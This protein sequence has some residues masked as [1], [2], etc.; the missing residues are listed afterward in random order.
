M[1]ARRAGGGC[2]LDGGTDL[3]EAG[4]RAA[5][6]HRSSDGLACG[7]GEFHAGIV[8]VSNQ[9]RCTVV[10]K[11]PL[12]ESVRGLVSD[13]STCHLEHVRLKLGTQLAY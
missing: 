8:N 13:H 1:G 6:V 2:L 12:L 7:P 11:E 9:H 5:N 3:R 10:P 4:S